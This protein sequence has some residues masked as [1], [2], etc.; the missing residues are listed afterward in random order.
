MITPSGPEQSEG[1]TDEGIKE[2]L[3]TYV[4]TS[5]FDK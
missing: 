3:N 4:E 1:Q 5:V 2:M